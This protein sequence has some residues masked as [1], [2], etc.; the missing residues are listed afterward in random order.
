MNRIEI[1]VQTYSGGKGV[2]KHSIIA[3]GENPTAVNAFK[4][5]VP[6]AC[7]PGIKQISKIKVPGL[8]H[9]K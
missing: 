2:V 6:G 5:R 9:T 1:F 4:I 3:V 7:G 8:F